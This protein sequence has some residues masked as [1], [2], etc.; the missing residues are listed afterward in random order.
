MPVPLIRCTLATLVG[1]AS[2]LAADLGSRSLVQ[3]DT[4]EWTMSNSSFNGNPFDLIA[5]AQFVH[6][7]SGTNHTT[8]M[9]YRGEN[10]WSFRFLG[11]EAGT[12]TFTTSSDD[13]DLDG[14]SGSVSVT[15]AATGATGLLTHV[16]NRFA[17]QRP[18]GGKQGFL[19]NIFQTDDSGP[20]KHTHL[21]S[22]SDDTAN[23]ARTY[24]RYARE[25]GFTAVYIMLNNNLLEMGA[26]AYNATNVADP[27]LHSFAV[28][29]TILTVGR[30]E[31]M[32]VY[33][34]R[35][36]DQSRKWTPVG[37]EGGINGRI[38]RRLTRYFAARLGP[39]S[40]WSM[41][42]GFDCHE[43]VSKSALRTWAD[44]FHSWLAWPHLLSARSV[45]L[46]R[47]TGTINGYAQEDSEHGDWSTAGFP[48]YATIVDLLADDAGQPHLLEERNVL[49]RWNVDSDDTRL[50]RWETA[51]AGG[52]GGWYGFFNQD[53]VFGNGSGYANDAAQHT[54]GLFWRDRF[55]LGLQRDNSITDNGF[56]LRLADSSA[57]VVFATGVDSLT[58][59]LADDAPDGLPVIAV[60]TTA[61]YNEL[62]MASVGPG[63]HT[64]LL[65]QVSD[66]ALAIGSFTSDPDNAPPVISDLSAT[67]A[68]VTDTTTLLQVSASDPDGDALNISWQA[69]DLPPGATPGIGAG[70]KATVTFDLAGTY[71]FTATVSDGRGGQASDTVSVT[72]EQHPDRL[73]ITP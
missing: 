20:Y 63:S 35:W 60:D 51:M 25:R 24:M 36:G 45:D 26:Y 55:L 71:L 2:L 69:T 30:E 15:P 14:H 64:I 6:P 58:L 21:T 44:D 1:L 10:E 42:Y 8:E 32:R 40:G 5:T 17:L 72:V 3:F 62:T 73:E 47:T 4:E 56:G 67:P 41:G 27:D 37:L 31:C 16:G 39:R 54:H 33:F 48:R 7:A 34:W 12:W 28:L 57:A 49:G 13:E 38:D 46:Q 29:D 53:P 18:D 52:M 43:W 19:L 11:T 59:D 68:I 65:P 66:W 9:F 50:L 70:A 23:R 61:S 22:F